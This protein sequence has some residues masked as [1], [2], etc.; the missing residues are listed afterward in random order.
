MEQHPAYQDIEAIIRNNGNA[1]PS[2]DSLI[3]KIKS[4]KA[5]RVWLVFT[6]DNPFAS[7]LKEEFDKQ[8][9]EQGYLPGPNYL[10]ILYKL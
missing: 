2:A 3:Q 8:F 1:M 10:I 9:K 7:S 5:G 4:D 6:G